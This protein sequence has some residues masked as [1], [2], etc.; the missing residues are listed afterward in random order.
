M[1]AEHREIGEEEGLPEGEVPA[2]QKGG[3]VEDT[4]TR[5]LRR[6]SH[7]AI[8]AGGRPGETLMEA[9]A[10]PALRLS[11]LLGGAEMQPNIRASRCSSQHQLQRFS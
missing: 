8:P 7:C 1:T 10:L 11:L 4:S 6:A 9:P 3:C 5:C 2:G